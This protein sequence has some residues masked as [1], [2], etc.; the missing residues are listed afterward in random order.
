EDDR[1]SVPCG[2]IRAYITRIDCRDRV[3]ADVYVAAR[4]NA[5]DLLQDIE[6]H[7]LLGINERYNLKLEHDL[8][9]LDARRNG[10]CV[11]YNPCSIRV[12]KGT[13]RNWNLLP[14]SDDSFFVVARENGWPR[15]N[16]E[17]IRGLQQMH[18]GREGVTSCHV[19][20]G[21]VAYVLDDLAE[22][23]QMGWIENI[24]DN[25]RHGAARGHGGTRD[26]NPRVIGREDAVVTRGAH[27]SPVV[28]CEPIDAEFLVVVEDQLP[29]YGAQ[30]HLRRFH[31]HF[32]ED[33]FH[34]RNHLVIA[35]DDD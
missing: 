17:S 15:N 18:N 16:S 27:E 29:N 7:F 20:I 11:V 14:G 2:N 24:A 5:V 26:G 1:R 3:A 31:V 25:R 21:S 8:L 19:N 32:V 9:V 33:L 34:L 22:V 10:S 35:E 12:C 23:N 30:R 28:L 13:Y 6:R 4:D